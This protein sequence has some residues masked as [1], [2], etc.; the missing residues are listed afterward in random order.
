M[1]DPTRP[2]HPRHPVLA[3]IANAM[4]HGIGL[5][6]SI[7]GLVVLVVLAVQRATA[8]EVVACSVYGATLILL[9]LASTLYHSLS[10]TRARHVMRVIDHAAI[11][12][13]IAGT[14]TPFALINLRGGWG[15]SIFGV[16]WALA[17]AGV[18]FKAGFTGRF[19][20]LSSI[21]YLAMGWMS[22]IAIRP[23]FEAIRLGGILWLAAGGL[24]YSVG[25][26]FYAWRRP[27][28]NHAIWHLFVMAG[29]LCHFVAVLLYSLPGA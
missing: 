8:R 17:V 4:T 27:V 10:S 3:E 20:I 23:L 6:L 12:L 28:Y 26:V 18:I 14:Y 16:T 19:R 24:C 2:D 9:Y 7:V 29:S 25:V 1:N 22:L 11:Y 13:L 15:W 5:L 21:I